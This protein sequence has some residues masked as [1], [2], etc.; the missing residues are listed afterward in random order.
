MMYSRRDGG[1]QTA[2]PISQSGAKPNLNNKHLNQYEFQTFTISGRQCSILA[3][4][5]SFMTFK[6][7]GKTFLHFSPNYSSPSALLSALSL[8]L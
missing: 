1:A 5:L 6:T 2:E 8:V 3:C 7:S 4:S